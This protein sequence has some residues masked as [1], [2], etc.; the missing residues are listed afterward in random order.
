MITPPD[1]SVFFIMLCFWAVFFVVSTQI[2]K[3]LLRILDER[4]Q[5]TE[6]ARSRLQSIRAAIASAM[7]ASEREL[8]AASAEATRERG[9]MR[10]E[11]EA[12]RRAR[13]DAARAQA[14]EALARLGSELDESTQEARLG[15]RTRAFQIARE[16]AVQLLGRR[17]AS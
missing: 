12:M 11:G 6:G 17:L 8:A 15:L 3:P 10:S 16:L 2:V 1:F 5:E 4:E 13:L 9:A 7:A 14:H